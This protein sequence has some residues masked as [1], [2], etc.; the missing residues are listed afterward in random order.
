MNNTPSKYQQLFAT[1]L[2]VAYLIANLSLPLFEGVHFL[3]HL[4]D[5]TPIHTFQSHNS[6]HQHQVLTII[7]QLTDNKSTTNPPLEQSSD[8][9]VKKVMQQLVDSANW[10]EPN[11]YIKATANFST[12]YT[13][14]KI[15]FLPIFAPPPEA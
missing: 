6:Q 9:Q 2:F 1:L 8:K 7:V 13:I 12:L 5:G 4:V 10:K 14:Y 11:N 15:P 3:L